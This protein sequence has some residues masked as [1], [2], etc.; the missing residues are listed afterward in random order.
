VVDEYGAPM[1]KVHVGAEIEGSG[2]EHRQLMAAQW[3]AQNLTGSATDE[4]PGHSTVS[5][6]QG[7]F[8]FAVRPLLRRLT[9]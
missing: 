7:Q 6:E 1:A 2:F 5:D 4:D 8:T 3:H 9:G